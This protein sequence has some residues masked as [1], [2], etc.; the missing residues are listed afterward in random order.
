MP[1][2]P[3]LLMDTSEDEEDINTLY[4]EKKKSTPHKSPSMDQKDSDIVFQLD[5][6]TTTPTVVG[7]GGLLWAIRQ[8]VAMARSMKK[9]K[10]MNKQ[11]VMKP[12]KLYLPKPYWSTQDEELYSSPP[13]LR[14]IISPSQYS[15]TTTPLPPTGATNTP[16]DTLP[17]VTTEKKV[18]KRKTHA[19]S[20]R[21]TRVK[22]PCQACQ[23]TSDGCMRKAFHWPFQTN[24]SYND[25]GKPFVY[26][27]NK[28]GLRYNKSGGCVCRNCRWVLCKEEKRKAMQLI[29]QMRLSRPD[30]KVDMDEDIQNFACT[31]KYWNCGCPWKVGWILN[32]QHSLDED[33][34]L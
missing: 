15:T 20:G 1:S 32:S 28:C 8:R 9:R 31:P 10:L 17:L 21:P 4:T 23:E 19:N 29:E 6:Q 26:L 27:C 24:N 33:D 5:D 34:T 13:P 16:A 22:G 18:Y 25:K 2:P 11:R 12:L 3:E 14:A 7:G 30:G